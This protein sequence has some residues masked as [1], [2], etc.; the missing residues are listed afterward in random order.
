MIVNV[1]S[2]YVHLS[3]CRNEHQKLKITIGTLCN[4]KKKSEKSSRKY[5]YL[6]MKPESFA[7][8]QIL[9][10]AKGLK[11]FDVLLLQN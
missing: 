5:T 7:F 3:Y 10:V 11:P 8:E 9:T 1:F 2:L 6:D 4:E